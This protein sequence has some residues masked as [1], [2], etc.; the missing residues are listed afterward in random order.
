V[1]PGE[2]GYLVPPESV[3]GLVEALCEIVEN[4]PK[5]EAMAARGREL[6]RERF[7]W[8]KMVEQLDAIYRELLAAH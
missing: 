8:R 1:L 4:R 7:P 3:D 2:T 6:C 5:A